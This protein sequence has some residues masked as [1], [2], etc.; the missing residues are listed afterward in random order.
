M[1]KKEKNK[2]ISYM[3]NMLLI[4]ISINIIIMLLS[5]LMYKLTLS[6]KYG[7]SLLTELFY[8]IFVL[9]VML[10]YKNF[11]VFTEKKEKFFKGLKVALPLI[12][13]SVIILIANIINLKSFSVFKFTNL[14]LF[15]L[16]IGIAEEF[17]CRGWLQNEFIERFSRNKKM[18]ISSIIIS[19]LIFGIMHITNIGTQSLLETI[20][21]IINATTMGFLLG[22]VYYK[23]KN[24]WSVIFLHAFYDFSIM[25]GDMNYVKDCIYTTPTTGITIVSCMS[26]IFIS[27][28]FIY[29]GISVL[30]KCDFPLEKAKSQKTDPYISM[31][32]YVALI[33]SFIPFENLVYEYKFYQVCYNY[34]EK[35]T[36]YDY[37][38]HYPNYKTY[39][40]SD[41]VENLKYEDNNNV[42]QEVI[43]VNNYLFSFRY[44]G[45][46]VILENKNTG[47]KVNINLPDIVRIESFKSGDDYIL[48]IHTLENESTVYYSDYMDVSNLSNEDKYLDNIKY[49][50]RRFEFPELTSVGYLTK[51][52][53]E[54][55]KY[56]IMTSINK[57]YFIIEDGRLYLIK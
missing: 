38:L 29:S 40:I 13:Y 14:L 27:F 57:D 52:N 10:S 50:F 37:T 17:L 33:M 19:S 53:D 21:Q 26:T 9:I 44:I 8:A 1:R 2:L 48:L 25:I 18:V 41:K 22:S 56:P 47:Y 46:N 16:F 31:V 28:F 23:T 32:I 54:N 12:I 3:L 4:F 34:N 5:R 55:I 36:D 24:I 42:S 20:L 11:Y 43:D 6:F 49:S 39:L 7:D 51:D 35:K 15:T 45:N 30:Q